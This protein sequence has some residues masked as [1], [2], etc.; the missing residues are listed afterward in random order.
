MMRRILG[1]LAV[2]LGFATAPE[3]FGQAPSAYKARLDAIVRAQEQAHQ[4]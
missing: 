2:M 1:V 4:R 3:A